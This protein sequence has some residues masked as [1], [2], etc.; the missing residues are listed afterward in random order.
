MGISCESKK[1]GGGS[2]KHWEL[3]RAEGLLGLALPEPWAQRARVCSE[4]WGEVTSDIALAN[5][6]S[7]TISQVEKL[8]KQLNIRIIR[9]TCVGVE[10]RLFPK[11][12]SE[13]QL[14][15]QFSCQF[16]FF[17]ETLQ[18]HEASATWNSEPP[19]GLTAASG[20]SRC[21]ADVRFSP[22]CSSWSPDQMQGLCFGPRIPEHRRVTF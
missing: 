21:S 11:L 22:A 18:K 13:T 10:K 7:I 16:L 2:G 15:L 12:P 19:W 5:I 4:W 9:K 17:Q 1:H 8:M 6:I 20:T 3:G 14:H